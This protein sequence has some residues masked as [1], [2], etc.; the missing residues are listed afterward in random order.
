MLLLSILATCSVGTWATRVGVLVPTCLVDIEVREESSKF[1]DGNPAKNICQAFDEA[2]DIIRPS[3][4][5][6]VLVRTFGWTGTD[7]PHW[8]VLWAMGNPPAPNNKTTRGGPGFGKNASK[9][10]P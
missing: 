1:D 4:A 6:F 8:Q 9:T 7:W 10:T 2:A 5:H 3:Q